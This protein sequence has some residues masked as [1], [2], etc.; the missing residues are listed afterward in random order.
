MHETLKDSGGYEWDS[1]ECMIQS[2]ISIKLPVMIL[3]HQHLPPLEY[4]E[5][6]VGFLQFS[7]E[8]CELNIASPFTMFYLEALFSIFAEF[9][10]HIQANQKA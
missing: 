9:I 5:H 1:F 7:L 2:A 10:N 3:E 8:I 4:S 6:Q